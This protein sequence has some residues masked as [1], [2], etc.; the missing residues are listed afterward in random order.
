MK[1]QLYYAP[2]T[3]AMVSYIG[4]TEAGAE[5]EVLPLN[6]RISE[7]LSPEY[8]AINPKHK[9]PMLVVDGKKITENVAIVSWVDQQFPDAKILPTDSWERVQAVS[10][11]SWC[12]GGIHPYLTRINNPA[13]VVDVAEAADGIVENAAAAIYE[14]FAIAEDMLAG[15]DW[16]FDDFTTPDAHFFWC[17]RRAGQFKLDT[18]QFK[19]CSAHFERVTN[20]DSTQKLLAFEKA[21]MA[22]FA[23]AA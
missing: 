12:S 10:L 7:H 15:R 21:T 23:A 5:F 18:A 22:K 9:V 20:R 4:L 19:N 13:K 17:F 8:M 6:F 14:N 2:I 1:I 16:F 11:H 3:C